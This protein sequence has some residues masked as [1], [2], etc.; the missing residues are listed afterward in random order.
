[1]DYYKFYL[2]N[3]TFITHKD[4]RLTK[5]IKLV[6]EAHPNKILD[7]GCGDGYLLK[8]LK[9]QLPK[10]IF[11]GVD[12]YGT[13]VNGIIL[14]TADITKGLPY[15]DK[16]FDCIIM[17]EII[18]HVPDPDF[19][20]RDV[21]R[22]LNMDGILII[23]TPNLVSWANRIMVLL[24][25]QPFFT[26]T[27]TERNLGRYFKILGQGQKTQGHLKIF[28]HK[29]LEEILRKEGFSVLSKYGVPFFFPFPFSLV[30]I[31]FTHFISLS[32]GLLY[33]CKYDKNNQI[34][35]E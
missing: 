2:N 14:K 32:S 5:I 29:S 26:E 27:S 21:R 18:E 35:K 15:R 28:T 20:L 34:N 23:S 30:D 10:S 33:L 3:K 31:I 9:K 7:I 17:G 19:V 22:I 4:F 11:N 12:V 1:M 6:S 25:I 24:G 16:S 8:E 13:K